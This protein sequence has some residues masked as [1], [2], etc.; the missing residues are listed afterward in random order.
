MP[1][2]L[3][4][5]VALLK[6]AAV[7]TAGTHVTA[8]VASHLAHGGAHVAA[9]FLHAA[10]T[11]VLVAAGSAGTA[12]G[13]M[14]VL[15][16]GG[17]DARNLYKKLNEI[18]SNEEE[19]VRTIRTDMLTDEEVLDLI[20]AIAL[21]RIA[22]TYSQQYQLWSRP[23]LDGSIDTARTRYQPRDKKKR[24]TDMKPCQSCACGDFVRDQCLRGS[25][26]YCEHAQ[27]QH[28]RSESTSNQ[29]AEPKTVEWVLKSL[30]GE[31]LYQLEHMDADGDIKTQVDELKPCAYCNCG[32]F[33]WKKGAA[34]FGKKCYCGHKNDQHTWSTKAE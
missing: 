27:S 11:N 30:A 16:N 19:L 8:G 6:A 12:A 13:A 9:N 26:C 29:L 17:K 22:E 33:D 5:L 28:F 34:L 10:G 15:F 18:E 31:A 1:L 14:H 21:Y 24:L 2:P 7:H 32:D 23:K 3:L 4:A 20:T 25:T